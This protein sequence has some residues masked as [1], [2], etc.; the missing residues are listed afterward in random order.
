M[1][2]SVKS[3]FTMSALLC[4]TMALSGCAMM[5]FAVPAAVSGCALDVNYTFTNIAYKTIC[6]PFTDVEVA[7]S[8]VLQKMN[9]KEK[10]RK[11]EDSKISV[12]AIAGNRD[13]Y[14]DLEK[15]TPTVT[16]MTV[17]AKKGVFLKD[18]ATATEII[19]Q[20][21]KFAEAMSNPTTSVTN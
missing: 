17:D 20:T 10:E 6:Y 8:E 9:I 19:V 12:L 4:L 3:V 11:S 7:L 5:G 18:K 2:Y 1:A 14:I 13:I 16:S 15:V 21:E